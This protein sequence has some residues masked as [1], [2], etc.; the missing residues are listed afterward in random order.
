[1]VLPSYHLVI[2]KL[3]VYS[4]TYKLFPE[5]FAEVVLAGAGMSTD[6]LH[7]GKMYEFYVVNGG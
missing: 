4:T 1:M 3:F 6:W 5:D 7:R 2:K